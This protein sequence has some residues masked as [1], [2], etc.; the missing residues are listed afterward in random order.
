[1]GGLMRQGEYGSANRRAQAEFAHAHGYALVRIPNHHVFGSGDYAVAAVL[2]A[3]NASTAAAP[4]T[5]APP[6]EGEGRN[7]AAS[8]RPNRDGATC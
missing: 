2:A 4:P 3:S 8:R 1:M 5:P 7:V 6:H